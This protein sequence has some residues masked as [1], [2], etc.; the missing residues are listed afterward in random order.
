MKRFS[1]L[2]LLSIFYAIP[3]YS[4]E[5]SNR[6]GV[7]VYSIDGVSDVRASYERLLDYEQLPDSKGVYGVELGARSEDGHGKT[8]QTRSEIVA[9][10]GAQKSSGF[11]FHIGGGYECDHHY[12]HGFGFL[13]DRV[14]LINCSGKSCMSFGVD[15]KFNF[16]NEDLP[17]QMRSNQ[18]L[19]LNPYVGFY[20]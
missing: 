9:F 2:I 17:N 16:K 6:F 3:S 19:S 5:S 14:G 12:G 18:Q 10:F 4:A 1:I 7:Q 13:S 20:F 15:L 8:S 11:L